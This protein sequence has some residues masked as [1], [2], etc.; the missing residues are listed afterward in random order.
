VFDQN[1]LPGASTI[2]LKTKPEKI[3]KNDKSI[4]GMY[5]IMGA[6]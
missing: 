6:S 3:L 1:P 4:K 2:S 5:I